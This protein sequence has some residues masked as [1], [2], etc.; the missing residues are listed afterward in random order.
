MV[1]IVTGLM[2]TPDVPDKLVAS[3]F[4]LTVSGFEYL[5]SV[6]VKI[7]VTCFVTS[8]V[9]LRPF[10]FRTVKPFLVCRQCA[11][12]EATG[13]SPRQPRHCQTSWGAL[14][15]SCTVAYCLASLH[16]YLFLHMIELSPEASSFR[17]SL[18]CSDGERLPVSVR[19]KGASAQHSGA[20]KPLFFFFGLIQTWI[21]S[22]PASFFDLVLSHVL[23]TRYTITGCTFAFAFLP[24][25]TGESG[26]FR[27]GPHGCFCE[28]R[29]SV[30]KFP[31]ECY[32][33]LSVYGRKRRRS[34]VGS[35]VGVQPCFLEII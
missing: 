29:V 28:W 26:R 25:T 19:L 21:R 2:P 22:K 11:R 34:W 18:F 33:C 10:R 12:G 17:F 24:C 4:L 3:K 5:S 8:R 20:K 16:V 7:Q 15:L 14:I 31:S 35:L 30:Q 6:G 27:P 23:K 1:T 9:A 32:K 13:I